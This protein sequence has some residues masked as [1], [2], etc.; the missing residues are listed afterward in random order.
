MTARKRTISNSHAPHRKH[1]DHLLCDG[2]D[3]DAAR[4]MPVAAAF[5]AHHVAVTLAQDPRWWI[6]YQT[7]S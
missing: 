3:I 2:A 4:T 6:E 5:P 7:A 1:H